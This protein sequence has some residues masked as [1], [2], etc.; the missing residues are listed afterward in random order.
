MNGI[1]V[2]RKKEQEKIVDNAKLINTLRQ[3]EKNNG[4]ANPNGGKIGIGKEFLYII[5]GS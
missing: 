5:H 2:G 3:A 4:E 1:I